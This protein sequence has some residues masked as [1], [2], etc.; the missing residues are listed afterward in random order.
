MPSGGQDDSTGQSGY[1]E[2]Q[3]LDEGVDG[4][5]TP[6]GTVTEEDMG[7]EEVIEDSSGTEEIIEDGTD[8]MDEIQEDTGVDDGSSGGELQEGAILEEVGPPTEGE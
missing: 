7:G 3:I 6:E 4:S 2:P 8:S 5:D 1:D